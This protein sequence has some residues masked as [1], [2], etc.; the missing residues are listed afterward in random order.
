MWVSIDDA[1]DMLS[2]GSMSGLFLVIADFV[3]AEARGRTW[4]PGSPENG[5][6]DVGWLCSMV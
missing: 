3:S 4:L 1:N 6:L 2:I 5:I